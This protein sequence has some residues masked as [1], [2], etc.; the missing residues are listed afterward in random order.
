MHEMYFS[1]VTKYLYSAPSHRWI[2]LHV[3]NMEFSLCVFFMS[4]SEKLLEEA[5]VLHLLSS[6]QQADTVREQLVNLVEH[7]AATEPDIS[8]RS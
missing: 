4:R 3:Y 2:L 5:T 6:K 7:L 1:T 8:P